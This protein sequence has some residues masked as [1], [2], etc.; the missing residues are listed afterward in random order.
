M[1]ESGKIRPFMIFPVKVIFPIVLPVRSIIFK[2]WQ[3][4]CWVSTKLMS[5][6]VKTQLVI[7]ND[8]VDLVIY[9]AGTR[10]IQFRNSNQ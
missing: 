6:N 8:V 7:N 4:S 9:L 10:L 1:M 2:A 3:I 5:F